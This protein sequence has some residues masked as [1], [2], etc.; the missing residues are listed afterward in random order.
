[1]LLIYRLIHFKDDI[2]DIDIGIIGRDKELIKPTLQLFQDTK[3]KDQLIAA[4]QTILDL[5]N[6]RKGASLE[7]Q[8]LLTLR[9]VVGKTTQPEGNRRV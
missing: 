7:A 2:P 1:M 4:F 8:L 5:K 6:Q 9:K 3:S